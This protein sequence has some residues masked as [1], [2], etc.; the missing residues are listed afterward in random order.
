[1]AALANGS[2]SKAT[3]GKAR[4]ERMIP[5]QPISTTPMELT[6]FS[7]LGGKARAENMTEEALAKHGRKLSRKRW[8]LYYREHPEKLKAKNGRR[9]KAA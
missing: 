3:S 7:R 6:E 4:A 1:M 2:T 8:A 5:E 9:S